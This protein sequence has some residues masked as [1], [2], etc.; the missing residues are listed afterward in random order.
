MLDYSEEARSADSLLPGTFP[1]TPSSGIPSVMITT[2][3]EPE[4][5]P[6]LASLLGWRKTQPALQAPD[7]TPM[8]IV[9]SEE[10]GDGSY[11]PMFGSPVREEPV[12]E[13]HRQCGGG[14]E[15]V[16]EM[17]QHQQQQQQPKH[18]S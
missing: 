11:V 2:E 15:R 12:A 8:S 1:D 9:M 5:Q 18:V 4:P 16:P 13:S 10:V 7:E 17:P 3:S 14:A 6:V